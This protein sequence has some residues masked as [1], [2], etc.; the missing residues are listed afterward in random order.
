MYKF[1]SKDVVIIVIVI[2]VTIIVIVIAIVVGFVTKNHCFVIATGGL[3][4][5]ATSTSL[6]VWAFLHMVIS[7]LSLHKK[8]IKKL[9]FIFMTLYLNSDVKHKTKEQ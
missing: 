1:R 6:L 5:T 9:T 2:L 3:I 7:L 4:S 8:D